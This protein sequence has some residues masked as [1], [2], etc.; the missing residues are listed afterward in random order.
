[1]Q[2][3]YLFD[4]IQPQMPAFNVNIFKLATP[5]YLVSHVHSALEITESLNTQEG[6]RH[7]QLQKVLLKMRKHDSHAALASAQAEDQHANKLD[8]FL[9]S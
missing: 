1:M 3:A 6:I 8:Y 5:E 2:Q 7:D 9:L 4:Y